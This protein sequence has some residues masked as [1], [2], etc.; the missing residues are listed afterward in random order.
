M[1]FQTELI[2]DDELQ[3]YSVRRKATE[4]SAGHQ[5]ENLVPEEGQF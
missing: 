2:S 4:K 1:L 3:W 5:A